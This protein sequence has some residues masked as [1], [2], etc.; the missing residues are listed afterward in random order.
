MAAAAADEEANLRLR[1]SSLSTSSTDD[2][3]LFGVALVVRLHVV[4]A[5]VA[6]DIVVVDVVVV[7]AAVRAV[8]SVLILSGSVIFSYSSNLFAKSVMEADFASDDDL[9]QTLPLRELCLLCWVV[10]LCDD[11]D[12][13]VVV[14]VGLWG[15]SLD[16]TTLSQRCSRFCSFAKAFAAAVSVVVV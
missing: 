6:V 14:A 3:S 5:V 11:D 13:E 4:P 7:A 15:F 8:R 12:D 16:W 10:W 2:E 9:P 1:V